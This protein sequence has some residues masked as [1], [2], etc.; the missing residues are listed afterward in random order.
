MA[1]SSLK[2]GKI[3]PFH[4]F[5]RLCLL[6]ANCPELGVSRSSVRTLPGFQGP[7]PFELETG[8]VGVLEEP[9]DVQLFYYFVKS[10]SDPKVDPLILWLTGGPGCS[11]FSG[12]V[13]EIGI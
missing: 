11:S 1:I 6:L 9:E 12:F 8:Y 7:L 2:A 13:Y 3:F 4:L 10:E 5:F